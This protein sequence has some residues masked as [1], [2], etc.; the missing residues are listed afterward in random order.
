MYI[1]GHMNYNNIKNLLTSNMVFE[2][3]VHR[4]EFGLQQMAGGVKFG[5]TI[6]KLLLMLLI[7]CLIVVF[8]RR[9]MLR[10]LEHVRLFVAI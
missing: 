2:I 10:C 9:V 8:L 5:R 1:V 6:D 4:I 3:I 7:Q